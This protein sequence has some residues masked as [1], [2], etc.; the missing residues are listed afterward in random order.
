M[1][2]STSQDAGKPS[3]VSVLGAKRVIPTVRVFCCLTP[4]L[5]SKEGGRSRVRAHGLVMTSGTNHD[6]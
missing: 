1:G 4:I 6:I 2:N 3:V 5:T